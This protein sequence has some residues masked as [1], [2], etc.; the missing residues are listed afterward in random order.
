MAIS[1][2]ILQP[3]YRQSNKTL[4]LFSYYFG[5]VLGLLILLVPLI[6]VN[7]IEFQDPE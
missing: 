7:L 6:V 3:G 4:I 5:L 2:M 1:L